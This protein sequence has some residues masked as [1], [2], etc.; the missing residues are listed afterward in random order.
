MTPMLVL[1]DVTMIISFSMLNISISFTKSIGMV[2][3]AILGLTVWSVWCDG[4]VMGIFTFLAYFPAVFLIMLPWDYQ[5]DILHSITKW[6]AIMLGIGLVEYLLLFAIPL[7]SLG[8]FVYPGYEPY[9]NYGFYIKTT[10]DKLIIP[11]FNACLLEPGHQA[12]V[13]TFLLIANKFNFRHNYYCFILLLGVICSFSL[14]GYLLLA[15]GWLLYLINDI[16]KTIIAG[17]FLT[18]VVMGALSFN[19][20]DNALYELIISRLEYDEEKGI[21]GNNRFTSDTDFIYERGQKSGMSWIGMRQK[22]NLDLI[23]GAGFKIYVIKYGWIG[24]IL[25]ALFYLSLIPADF[26]KRYTFV[27]LTVLALCFVQRA[28][29]S[30]YS[31]YFP[32]IIGIYLNRNGSHDEGD[33]DETYDVDSAKA[34][35]RC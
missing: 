15:A 2:I 6:Y 12:L 35:K 19:G 8:K 25:A 34:L 13:S 22:A 18:V 3:L 29:P 20:G 33:H 28:Y 17:A 30:W 14:A 27:F 24:V 23:D 31:W 4:T 1:V 21:K 5:K 10:W 7:P 26:N 16:R 32:Y 9:T 11:R